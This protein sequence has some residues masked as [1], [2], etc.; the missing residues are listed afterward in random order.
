MRYDGLPPVNTGTSRVSC[1]FSSSAI[2]GHGF[3]PDL[4][5]ANRSLVHPLPSSRALSKHCPIARKCIAKQFH[6]RGVVAACSDGRVSFTR[7]F[8]CSTACQTTIRAMPGAKPADVMRLTASLQGKKCRVTNSLENPKNKS[9]GC[10]C[11][12][13]SLLC[14]LALPSFKLS[15]PSQFPEPEFQLEGSFPFPRS[16]QL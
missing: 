10:V 1:L 14:C 6:E 4:R 7:R 12:R 2:N 16:P 15:C 13:Q 8:M 9:V 3:G 5:N 11:E